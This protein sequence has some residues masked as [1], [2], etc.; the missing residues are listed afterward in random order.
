MKLKK[1]NTFL[2]FKSRLIRYAIHPILWLHRAA[3]D[4]SLSRSLS[5]CVNK[6]KEKKNDNFKKWIYIWCPGNES[7]HS[8]TH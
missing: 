5:M 2:E 8:I 3:S 7:Q 6:L 4:Y 1:E